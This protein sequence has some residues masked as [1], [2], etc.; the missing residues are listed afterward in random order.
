[1]FTINQILLH[2]VEGL[3]NERFYVYLGNTY[4]EVGTEYIIE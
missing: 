3:Y 4:H 1:M 2:K